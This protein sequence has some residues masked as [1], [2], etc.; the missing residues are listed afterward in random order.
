[1]ERNKRATFCIF[2]L[3]FFLALFSTGSFSA[4]QDLSSKIAKVTVIVDGQPG[5][6]DM[7]ELISIKEGD[8]F[9]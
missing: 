1:M 6:R 9:S 8:V 3:V 2:L 4:S 5:S 7:E